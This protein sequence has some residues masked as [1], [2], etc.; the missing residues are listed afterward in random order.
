MNQEE[1]KLG[2]NVH[3]LK[4]QVDGNH[5]KKFEYQPIEFFQDVNLNVAL[6]YAIKYVSRYPNKNADDLD[7]AIHCLELFDDWYRKQI[8]KKENPNVGYVHVNK[9]LKFTHQFEPNTSIAIQ[10]ILLLSQEFTDWDFSE[11]N[12]IIFR[13]SEFEQVFNDAV[14]AIN[15]LQKEIKP[16]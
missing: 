12:E 3:P 11:D 14:E 4:K 8:D 13:E 10:K 1:E 5:Y 7:K 16:F 15:D 9:L 2:L 6:S